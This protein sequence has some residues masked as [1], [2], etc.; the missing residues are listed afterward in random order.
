MAQRKRNHQEVVSDAKRIESDIKAKKLKP[1]YLLHGEE[2]YYIDVLTKHIAEHVLE[3][4]ERDF[5]LTVL[6]AA[7]TKP[8]EVASL[9]RQYPVMAPYQVIIVKECQVWRSFDGLMPIVSHPVASTVV[10]LNLKGKNFDKRLLFYKNAE[11]VGEVFQSEKLGEWD[12]PKWIH[13]HC[14]DKKISIEDRAIAQL[15]DHIGNHLGNLMNALEKLQVVCSK[16]GTITEAAVLENIGIS[17]DFNVF[18]LNK[19]IGQRNFHKALLIANYFA[20]NQKEH[21]I[22]PTLSMVYSYFRKLALYHEYPNKA[23]SSGLARSLGLWGS[24]VNE[25]RDAASRYPMGSV[26]QALDVIHDID[27]KSKGVGNAS[28]SSGDLVKELVGRLMRT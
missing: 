28:A 7:D 18:E 17:K 16:E 15:S 22:I 21:H 2:P 8:E 9:A 14:R 19:A 11:K 3:D 12:V 23:D 24:T 13:H 4:H 10:V 27:L 26:V 5:N 25:Y 6:Y 20:N 1:L